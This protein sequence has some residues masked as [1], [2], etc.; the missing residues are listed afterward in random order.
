MKTAMMK[1]SKGL[2]LPNFLNIWFQYLANSPKVSSKK[3]ERR[4][5]W[6]L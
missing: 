5:S 1:I 2:K 3:R 6:V 4:C